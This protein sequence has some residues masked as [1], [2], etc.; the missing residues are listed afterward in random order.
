MSVEAELGAIS[1]IEGEAKAVST[2]GDDSLFTDPEGAAEFLRRSGADAL[3]VSVGTAHGVYTSAPEIKIELI[4]K[5]AG[6]CESPLVLHGATGVPDEAI[7]QAVAAGIR[8]INY[9]SD[10]LVQAMEF[11]RGFS[12]QG[13]D[14]LAFRDELMEIWKGEAKKLISLY[15]GS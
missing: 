7:R 3:A 8:K 12:E 9:F 11:I 13:N 1:G 5:I 14:Y 4:R 10:F 2:D 15:R 6:L